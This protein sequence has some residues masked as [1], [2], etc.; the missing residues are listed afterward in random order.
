MII[1]LGQLFVSRHT[2][3]VS[4]QFRIEQTWLLLFVDLW[5]AFLFGFGGFLMG[6]GG[7]K[8]VVLGGN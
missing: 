5:V 8:Y 4:Y 3:F 1:I 6:C 7:Q 2:V